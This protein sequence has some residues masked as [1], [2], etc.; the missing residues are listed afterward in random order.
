MSFL[1]NLTA[2]TRCLV[3]SESFWPF[4]VLSQSLKPF[5]DWSE[6]NSRVDAVV[7]F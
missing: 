7:G 2:L 6:F 3:G 5:V 4:V 1:W